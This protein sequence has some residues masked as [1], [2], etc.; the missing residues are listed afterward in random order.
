MRESG[1][2]DPSSGTEDEL[3]DF[4]WPFQL[5]K[6]PY[7]FLLQAFEDSLVCFSKARSISSS[8]V[9]FSFHHVLRF[10]TTRVVIEVCDDLTSSIRINYR[11]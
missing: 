5:Y 4:S 7:S 9:C 3:N 10:I 11:R 8:Q 6:G 1:R 2:A